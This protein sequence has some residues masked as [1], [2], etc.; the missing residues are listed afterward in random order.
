MNTELLILILGGFFI[1]GVMKKVAKFILFL[2]FVAVLVLC[3]FYAVEN[4]M[5]ENILAVLA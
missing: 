5:I 2:I 4:G 1:F 3:Y